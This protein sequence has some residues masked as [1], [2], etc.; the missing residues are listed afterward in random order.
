MTGKI[1]VPIISLL[2]MALAAFATLVFIQIF[3]LSGELRNLMV[4]LL[5]GFIFVVVGAFNSLIQVQG[6]WRRTLKTLV[7]K[8]LEG[9]RFL[10][11]VVFIYL[12]SLFGL[13]MAQLLLRKVLEA[14]A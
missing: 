8:D 11:L 13:L 3:Q 1:I 2:F 7:L 6:G 5:V 10:A 14:S 12:L 9:L 4:G